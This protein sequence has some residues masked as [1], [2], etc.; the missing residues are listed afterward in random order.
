MIDRYIVIAGSYDE[1][2]NWIRGDCNRRWNNGDTS[3]SMSDYIIPDRDMIRG[4]RN[5][6]GIFIGRWRSRPNIKEII[7]TL[8][9]SSTVENP[10][11]EK[12]YRTL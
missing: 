2:I 3:C 6:H 9:V 7:Q 12:L 1:A 5:P 11:L 4:I 8:L 10:T